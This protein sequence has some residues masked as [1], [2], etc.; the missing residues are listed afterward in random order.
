MKVMDR[1]GLLVQTGPNGC[2]LGGIYRASLGL[3][4]HRARACRLCSVWIALCPRFPAPTA[5]A[6]SSYG[7]NGRATASLLSQL[8]AAAV[9]SYGSKEAV[10]FAWVVATNMFR[11]GASKFLPSASKII[12]PNRNSHLCK[13]CD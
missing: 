6:G 10:L 11:G 4:G 8:G 1:I 5:A 2:C 12:L 9:S 3:H 7:R 13:K